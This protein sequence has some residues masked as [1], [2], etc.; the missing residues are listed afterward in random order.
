MSELYESSMEMDI[1]EN[2]EGED[3]IEEFKLKY[4]ELEKL[5]HTLVSSYIKSEKDFYLKTDNI[6]NFLKIDNIMEMCR[7]F[8]DYYLCNQTSIL[9]IANNILEKSI[10][11]NNIL[12]QDLDLDLYCKA[13][14]FVKIND[15]PHKH[16]EL[17]DLTLIVSKYY[18]K[19]I[20]NQSK[21]NQNIMK[22]SFDM[23]QL[24]DALKSVFP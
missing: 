24:E 9:S 15:E 21:Y 13:Y 3:D 23:S 20:Q 14:I 11:T 18:S 17:I 1:E 19:Y 4:N 12:N 16:E 7:L 22:N 2:I 10:I 5:F 6:S 8:H